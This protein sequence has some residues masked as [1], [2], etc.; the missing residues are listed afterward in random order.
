MSKRPTH[1]LV[2]PSS[3]G[4]M[5]VQ[6]LVWSIKQKFPTVVSKGPGLGGDEWGS[7]SANFRETLT[8][9][10]HSCTTLKVHTFLI[11]Q[12][13]CL[14]HLTLVVAQAPRDINAWRDGFQASLLV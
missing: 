3:S 1:A 9:K 12:P 10:V 13:E 11:L 5:C 7:K 6:Q 2:T 4:E 14:T 8:P